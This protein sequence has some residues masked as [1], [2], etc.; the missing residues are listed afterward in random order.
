[1]RILRYN[2]CNCFI[3]NLGSIKYYKAVLK[4][5][6]LKNVLSILMP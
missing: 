4:I 2:E 1:M 3:E 6:R 5:K